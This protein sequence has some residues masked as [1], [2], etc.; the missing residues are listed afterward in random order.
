MSADDLRPSAREVID[1]AR[2]AR[3]PSDAQRDR[4][5][6]A[7]LA[8][9]S[10]GAAVGT[11]KVVGKSALV[12]LKWA[13][14]AALVVASAGTYAWRA[15]RDAA[16][17]ASATGAVPSIAPVAAP[18]APLAPAVDSSAAVAVDESPT[19]SALPALKPQASAKPNSDDL[20]QELSL[21]HQALAASRSGNAESALDLARQHAQ[22]YPN[23]RLRN[24]RDAI[25]VRS[26]CAL[27]RAI[28]AKK[29]ADRLRA[30][31][32]NSPVSAALQD[33]CVGK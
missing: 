1:V 15:H 6:Q 29:I 11:A 5:Y 28:D 8:G 18:S 30:R 32:P 27:G 16:P 12:W 10:G 2:R 22:R 25:E 24:E 20:V 4:A 3:T 23:S 7:L 13:I 21:L 17:I 14:P 19:P 33:S 26:L 9:L 31:A